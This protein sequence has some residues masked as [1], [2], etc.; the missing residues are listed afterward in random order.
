MGR[1]AWILDAL[2][3]T[4]PVAPGSPPS[5]IEPNR[6]QRRIVSLRHSDT[7]RAN[8]IAM[9]VLQTTF[10]NTALLAC[11]PSPRGTRTFGV[12]APTEQ[13]RTCRKADIAGSSRITSELPGTHP[14]RR[15]TLFWRIPKRLENRKMF[16]NQ[17]AGNLRRLTCKCT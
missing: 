7:C 4:M 14:E 10:P 5:A 17:I 11:L 1:R 8:P 6:S 9:W 2:L 13:N 16:V 15:R 3:S 12:S